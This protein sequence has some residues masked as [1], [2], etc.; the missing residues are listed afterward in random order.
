METV[1]HAYSATP[2]TY[3]NA[4]VA[5]AV[6]VAIAA[7][8]AVAVAFPVGM[9]GTANS[10]AA[11]SPPSS[12][13]AMPALVSVDRTPVTKA[14]NAT[15]AMSWLRPGAICVMRPICV[16]SEPRLPKPQRL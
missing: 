3:N 14:L 12:K 15:P 2:T 5:V 4:A 7:A 16:P 8:A 1:S 13:P 10:V 6:A 11:V 9:G